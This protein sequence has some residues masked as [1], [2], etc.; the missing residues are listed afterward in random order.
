MKKPA[1][2]RGRVERRYVSSMSRITARRTNA[3]YPIKHL[4]F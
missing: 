2:A 1:V 4:H 3:M